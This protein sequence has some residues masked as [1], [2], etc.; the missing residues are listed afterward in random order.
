MSNIFF[1]HLHAHTEYSLLD[2]V[3]SVEDSFTHIKNMK[4]TSLAITDHGNMYGVPRFVFHAQKVGLKPIIG[5]ELYITSG[6]L[7]DKKDKKIYHQLVLSKNLKGYQNLIQLCSLGYTHGFYYKPRVDLEAIKKYAEGLIATTGCLN[8]IIAQAIL[9]DRIKEAEKIFLEWLNIFG[10]DYYIELQRHGIKEQ[11][12]LNQILLEWHKKYRVKIIATNDSH[13]VKKEDAKA[14]DVLLCIQTGKKLT[15]KQRLKF[16]QDAFYLKSPQEMLELFSDY[17]EAIENTGEIVDK[18]ESFSLEREILMPFFPIPTK[19]KS[20][21][22]YLQHLAYEGIKKRYRNV[23]EKI[24]QRLKRELRTISNKKFS[25]YFLVV[26]DFVNEA[27]RRNIMVGPGRGSIAGSIVAYALGITDVDPLENNL[28]FERFLIE[29]GERH[30]NP[31]IDIDFEEKRRMEIIDYVVKKYGKPQVAQVTT[32][33]I[34]GAKSAVRDTARVIE[35]PLRDAD[36]LAKKIP[37]Q[38]NYSLKKAFQ[39]LPDYKNIFSQKKGLPYDT[40]KL[41]STIEGKIRHVGIHAAALIISPYPITNYVPVTLN[42]DTQLL[43][44]QYDGNTIEKVGMLKI[45]FL[46]IKTLNV[47]KDCLELVKKN[48]NQD[49][50]LLNLPKKDEK[51]FHLYQKGKTIGT[52]QFESEGMRQYLKQLAPNRF[53]DLV[54]MNALYRPGPM[55]F[56]PSFIRRKHGKEKIV[57]PHPLLKEILTSTYGIVVYQEQI[58]KIARTIA[59]YSPEES[60]MIRWAMGKKKIKEME[61]HRLI[62]INGAQK[63][64]ALSYEEAEDIFKKMVEFA[65]YGFNRSHSFS[66]ATIAYQ[67]A[68]CKAHYPEEYMVALL[69]NHQNDIKKLS[70]FLEETKNMGIQVLPPH[71]NN[72][73]IYFKVSEKNKIRF[74]LNA[75]KGLR[76][77]AN[78]IVQER[79]K[80]GKYK[81]IYDFVQRTSK[82]KINKAVYHSLAQSGC[83][84]I[85]KIHRKQYVYATEGGISFIA[86]LQ[87]QYAK[88]KESQQLSLFSHSMLHI[89]ELKLPDC[90]KYT[91]TEKLLLEKD[92][93]GLYIS[94]HPLDSYKDYMHIYKSSDLNVITD[95][96]KGQ[97]NV[98]AVLRKK[99][100]KHN[101]KG[102]VFTLIYLEDMQ[103]QASL[104]LSEKIEKKYDQ[105]LQPGQV[106]LIKL[107]GKSRPQ[108]HSR[109]EKQQVFFS[110]LNCKLLSYVVEN[111]QKDIH[112]YVNMETCTKKKL[113]LLV[114]HISTCQ[115]KSKF[116][117]ILHDK[118]RI[119]WK[120]LYYSKVNLFLFTKKIITYRTRSVT[121]DK[122]ELC[123]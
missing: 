41:A 66:Y 27:K 69:S 21:D 22:L 81:D 79:N 35:L 71:I 38:P 112:V 89:E 61:R 52:F 17:P 29:E 55:K 95:S 119:A 108:Y 63:K 120:L 78:E 107:E 64:H 98:V 57:Y 102:K 48:K 20:Q 32:F 72:S 109:E 37:N 91:L 97:Y 16:H 15:D 74:G 34:I 65:K 59:Y 83:F 82:C 56:I 104:F 33:N 87:K 31:D 6:S 24:K 40:L 46:G 100:K 9:Q 54:A 10:E 70:F 113:S 116:Y 36:I 3:S 68:Y 18:I 114:N 121:N 88:K 99:E 45:D 123:I 80:N 39:E 5:C 12:K 2:G 7:H 90:K 85:W 110:I 14:H 23:N 92:L 11:D 75:I 49:I 26:Q 28:L 58:M 51:T 62:F 44:T 86:Q 8:S 30:T 115:G 77:A 103:Q 93:L 53:E 101:K 122:I 67:T 111:H 42:R 96:K 47:L 60:D 94:G 117:L 13:Y 19:F 76:Q 106:V 4:M 25:G 105:I 43:V 84:D 118:N 1:S 73:N 50:D